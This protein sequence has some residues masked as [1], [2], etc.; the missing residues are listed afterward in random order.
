MT[1]VS[2]HR[3][4]LGL[5]LRSTDSEKC[6]MCFPTA[7]SAVR[8]HI[9]LSDGSN[10]Q[11][12]VCLEHTGPSSTKDVV[13]L[14]GCGHRFHRHCLMEFVRSRPGEVTASNS[15]CP[16][17]RMPLQLAL[18]IAKPTPGTSAPGSNSNPNSNSNSATASIS[19]P[20][21]ESRPSAAKATG[22]A[23]DRKQMHMHPGAG[24][25]AANV[26]CIYTRTVWFLRLLMPVLCTCA[27]AEHSHSQSAF[28]CAIPAHLEL[29][30]WG[31]WS[32]PS[33]AR[34]VVSR[35]LALVRLAVSPCTCVPY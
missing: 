1:R 35:L 29:R 34:C 9:C 12:G 14:P 15:T 4:R 24:V 20:A 30:G 27:G 26:V 23:T 10:R 18:G 32:G 28:G 22:T 3:L 11:C 25:G 13:A 7:S 33:A 6:A 8:P 5:C 17:C 31:C 16:E 19:A 21:P 2:P